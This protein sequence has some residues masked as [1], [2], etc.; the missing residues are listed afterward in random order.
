MK[1]TSMIS[2]FASALLA[3][4]FSLLPAWSAPTNPP[5]LAAIQP[6]GKDSS[7]PIGKDSLKFGVAAHTIMLHCPHPTVQVSGSFLSDLGGTAF[8]SSKGTLYESFKLS[9]NYT[10][11]LDIQSLSYQDAFPI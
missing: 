3:L 7:Q 4:G 11:L 6:I 10:G 2:V 8:K 9:T 5:T 1:R